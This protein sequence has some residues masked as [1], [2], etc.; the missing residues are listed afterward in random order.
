ML[1]AGNIFT[2]SAPADQAVKISDGVRAP[3]TDTLPSR[4]VGH[5][6]N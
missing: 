4:R 2:T 3:G 5:A 6:L 1:V